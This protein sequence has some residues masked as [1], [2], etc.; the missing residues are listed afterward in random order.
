M[1]DETDPELDAASRRQDAADATRFRD[2]AA[3]LH[4]EAAHDRDEA[5]KL[6]TMGMGA[7]ADRYAGDA[8]SL[9]KGAADFEHRADLLDSAIKHRVS[10]GHAMEIAAKADAQAAAAHDA[11]AQ[12]D[13][14]LDKPIGDDDAYVQTYGDAAAA[15]AREAALRDVA[16]SHRDAA[17]LEAKDVARI[18]EEEAREGLPGLN[19]DAPVVDPWAAPAGEPTEPKP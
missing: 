3:E 2:N 7:D 6:R 1:V 4:K 19:D 14:R 13:V 10:A 5:T 11:A 15:H 17:K 9:D 8:S 16:T 18:R 12:L